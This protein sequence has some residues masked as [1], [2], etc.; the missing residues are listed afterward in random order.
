MKTALSIK[1]ER[2]T[3]HSELT[4]MNDLALREKRNFTKAEKAKYE[5]LQE[6]FDALKDQLVIAEAEERR[7]LEMAD[8]IADSMSSSIKPTA[9]QW[10]ETRT[11][12][13]IPVFSGNEKFAD[14][15]LPEERNLSIGR[16]ITG[17]ITNKWDHAQNELRALGTGPGS[18]GVLVPSGFYASIIDRAR[19]KTVCGQAGAKFIEMNGNSM[20]IA[21][22]LTD[23]EIVIKPEN[24]QF[25]DATMTFDALTLSSFTLGAVVTM[26]RELAY[27]AANAATAVEN[28]LVQALAL[29]WDSLCMSGAGT[30]EPLGLLNLAGVQEINLLDNPLNYTSMLQA[31]SKIITAN[32]NPTA[33]VMSPRDAATIAAITMGGQYVVAPELIKSIKNLYTSSIPT[34]LGDGDESYAFAG[35][36]SKAIFGIRESAQIEVSSTAGETFKRHQIAVKITFRGDIAFEQPSHFVKLT[37]IIGI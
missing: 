37:N 36:F 12:R 20:T 33:Y 8:K 32:G 31:W 10:I 4:A 11:G 21:R 26:S 3:I 9:E 18:A 19:A 35:D 15:L 29:K 22:V 13:S 5:D 25:P 27:D 17:M 24:D 34:G 16:L 7:N 30:V 14:S 23:P 28:A 1:Q 6:Q 2:G